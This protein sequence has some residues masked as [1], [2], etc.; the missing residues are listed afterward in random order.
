LYSAIVFDMDGVLVDVRRSYKKAVVETVALL[1]SDAQCDAPSPDGG[2]VVAMKAAG[3]FNNDWDLSRALVRGCLRHQQGFDIHGYASALQA[4]G[5]G[6][7]AVDSV[8]G[9][10]P[11]HPVLAADAVAED[12]IKRV[13]QEYY[14]GESL[15]ERIYG[16]CRETVVDS[17]TGLIDD[18]DSIV[19]LAVL[20]AL[21]VPLG[22]ATGRPTTEAEYTLARFGLSSS[23]S[24]VVTHDDVVTSG[25]RGK[26]DPWVLQET[27]RRLGMNESHRLAYVGDLPDDMRAAV[28]AGFDPIGFCWESDV[29]MSELRA[30]GARVV[31][32]TPSEL[33]SVLRAS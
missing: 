7:A 32:Q 3:G 17:P 11:P 19:G 31:C 20:D 23:F 16:V 21:S 26:P 2:W 8:L 33:L 30:A 10:A 29:E 9:L 22:L 25:S 15:F 24:V 6:P 4:F 28:G 5:G 12:R 18:E 27:R 1:C 13:F 14:L